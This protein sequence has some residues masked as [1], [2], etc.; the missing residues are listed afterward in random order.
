MTLRVV[1]SIY[2]Q[3]LRLKLKGVPV[4]DHPAVDAPSPRASP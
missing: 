4:H 3:A 2:W 1:A